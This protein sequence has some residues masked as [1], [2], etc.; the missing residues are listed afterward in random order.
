MQVSRR[1]FLTHALGT[2]AACGLAGAALAK[3]D[4]AST[5]SFVDTHVY[6]GHW[7]HKQLPSAE[8][9]ELV[10]TLGRNG[11]GRAWAGSFDGLFHKDID[12]VNRRLA[13]V[14]AQPG[15]GML[16][17][18]GSINPMLPDWEEDVRRCHE[19][20]QMLCIRLH[21]NYHGYAADD[22]RFARVLELAAERG[23]IVQL[24]AWMDERHFLLSPQNTTV[25]LRS[26][27]DQI[28]GVKNLKLVLTNG[29]RNVDE[30]G[31]RAVL[32][33]KQVYLDF[34]RVPT[35]AELRQL[36]GKA[37]ASRVV[38]GSGAPLHESK[39]QFDTMQ[40]AGLTSVEWQAIAGGNANRLTATKNTKRHE[41]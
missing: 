26:L 33:M 4:A 17:P 21:P 23:L 1:T 37:S 18:V 11:I 36:I 19:T 2:T 28:A 31:I 7:P 20:F 10:R 14:C 9:S 22:R 24:I 40:G 39:K 12:A 38:F 13:E 3:V 6:L 15:N 29:C 16:V 25:D 34:G 27:A 32:P 5:A 41:K 35:G 30:D 8:T